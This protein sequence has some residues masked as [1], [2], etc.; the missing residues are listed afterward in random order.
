MSLNLIA[1]RAQAADPGLLEGQ[2]AVLST[3]L[4]GRLRVLTSPGAPAS[5][6][7][8]YGVAGEVATYAGLQ[9]LVMLAGRNAG[10][11]IRLERAIISG[12]ANAAALASVYLVKRSTLTAGG[13]QGGVLGNVGPY[14]SSS[15]AT[16]SIVKAFDGTGMAVG[17]LAVPIGNE[18]IV[19]ASN[20]APGPREAAIFDWSEQGPYTQRPEINGNAECLCLGFYGAPTFAGAVFQVQLQW[21]EG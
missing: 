17:A 20:A 7:A 3:D 5:D 18:G 9:D 10:T 16:E 6:G 19:L 21:K 4:S 14:V 11:R 1:A 12:V 8:S 2:A 15:P 13:Q